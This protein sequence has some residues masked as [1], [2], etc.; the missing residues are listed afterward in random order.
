MKSR[1]AKLLVSKSQ[2][3][4]HV[5][6]MNLSVAGIKCHSFVTQQVSVLEEPTDVTP[7]G[8]R[9]PLSLVGRG[10]S[11]VRPLLPQHG[12][13]PTTHLAA[14]HELWALRLSP[15]AKASKAD[16]DQVPRPSRTPPPWWRPPESACVSGPWTGD[17]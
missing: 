7:A 1:R 10:G 4:P 5:L 9:R 6:F 15:D 11:R 12:P 2:I 8:P 17:I 13:S 16:T 14:S 3:K